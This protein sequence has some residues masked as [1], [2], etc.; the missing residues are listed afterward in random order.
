MRFLLFVLALFIVPICSRAQ[1]NPSSPEGMPSAQDPAAGKILERVSLRFNSLKSLQ[2][3]FELVVADRKENTSNA[4]TGSLVMKQKKYRLNSGGSTVFF[5]GSTMWTYVPANNEVTVTKPE[6]DN[7]DF[8]SNPATFF[9][10]YKTEFKYRLVKETNKNGVICSE[11]DLFPKNLNQPYSR[12]KVF[13]NEKTDLP[14]AISSIGKDGIDYTVTLKNAVLDKE[15]PDSIFIFD[16]A[17]YRKVEVV[18]MR[19]I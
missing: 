19:G 5:D 2:T 17:K 16:S 11:I 18:D 1:E 10:T 15:F 13:I 12:I 3:D 7:A 8:M 4:S 9:D 6:S 14:V